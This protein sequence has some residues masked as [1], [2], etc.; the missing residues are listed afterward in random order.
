MPSS[1]PIT[2]LADASS[3]PR[4]ITAFDIPGLIHGFCG[5]TGGVS[6]GPFASFNL[7]EWI[8]DDPRSI[9]E[10]WRRWK[11]RYP[12]L[13]IARLRQVHGALV[14]RADQAEAQSENG[15]TNDSPRRQGD[16]MVTATAGVAL[17]IFTADCVP[18]LMVDADQRIVAALHAGW[19]GTLAGIAGE[20]VRAMRAL[21]ARPASIRAALGPA[22]GPCC[23]EV[24]A[25]LA[26]DFARQIPG[27]SAY[28][29][30]GCPGKAYLDLR[31]IV[32][33]QLAREGLEVR[34]I[35]NVGPCTRCA[36]DTYFSRRGA[37]ADGLHTSGLQMSFI[38][39]V[40]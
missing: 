39:F 9:A 13:L 33:Q 32:R 1:N 5:R 15:S 17:G 26:E 6:V 23:F 31:S 22:I 11:A 24:D 34:S 4:T 21:G 38:G 19:R 12:H 16:G 8:G 37:L 36:N 30:A 27:A 28:S 25:V 2:P 18:I 3:G 10:N 40:K 14:H 35:V 20:G 7:A 29:R